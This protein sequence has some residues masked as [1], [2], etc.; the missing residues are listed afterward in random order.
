MRL[1]ILLWIS[2]VISNMSGVQLFQF[3]P[4]YPPGEEPVDSGEEIGDEGDSRA[5]LIT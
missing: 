3:E 4:C 5:I 1:V 2:F